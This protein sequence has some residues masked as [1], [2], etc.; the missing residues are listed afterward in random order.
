MYCATE[1]I[2]AYYCLDNATL[3]YR[4]KKGYVRMGSTG[5]RHK[6]AVGAERRYYS[7]VV[8]RRNDCSIQLLCKYMLCNN[9]KVCTAK[10]NSDSEVRLENVICTVW[11]SDHFRQMG[12]SSDVLSK[13]KRIDRGNV[14]RGPRRRG[15][16]FTTLQ[17]IIS[18][19][20]LIAYRD[21]LSV[22]TNHNLLKNNRMYFLFISA[23]LWFMHPWNRF[24]QL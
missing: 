7:N 10:C 2:G 9:Q 17:F 24:L 22:L 1:Y 16:T 13:K 11:G 14:W 3:K 15:V 12:Y 23:Q 18:E 8:I 4:R 19:N 20:N 21:H 5:V 6:L